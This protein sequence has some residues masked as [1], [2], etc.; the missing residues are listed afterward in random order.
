LN[1]NLNPLATVLQ[2]FDLGVDARRFVKRICVVFRLV[3]RGNRFGNPTKAVLVNA[4]RQPGF[5]AC[6]ATISMRTRVNLDENP[7]WGEAAR[8]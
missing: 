4:D 5:V 6:R 7:V 2:A 1:K 3:F 8:A